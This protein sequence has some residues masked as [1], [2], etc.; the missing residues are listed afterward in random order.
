LHRLPSAD[1]PGR[2][3]LV[4]GNV[5]VGSVR[6]SAGFGRGPV[7]A[8]EQPRRGGGGRRPGWVDGAWGHRLGPEWP[9]WPDTRRAAVPR[10]GIAGDEASL[11]GEVLPGAGKPGRGKSA[12]GSRCRRARG[13]GM[14]GLW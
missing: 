12:D 9:D 13:W 11:A 8:P 3:L 6:L 7:L 14:L 2:I 10:T 5:S 4:S 1:I